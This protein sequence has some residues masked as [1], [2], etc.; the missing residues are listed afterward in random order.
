MTSLYIQKLK[1]K[2]KFYSNV[3]LLCAVVDLH[4]YSIIKLG[5]Q[6]VILFLRHFTFNF[7]FMV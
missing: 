1:K 4:Y 6:F 7:Y 5:T 3:S 2:S